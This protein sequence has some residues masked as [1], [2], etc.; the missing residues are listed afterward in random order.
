MRAEGPS[1]DQRAFTFSSSEGSSVTSGGPIICSEGTFMRP[2]GPLVRSKTG[3]RGKGR[4]ARGQ[5]LPPPH[6]HGSRGDKHIFC[7]P[8]ISPG[9]TPGE[10]LCRQQK[11]AFHLFHSSEGRPLHWLRR[12]L[13]SSKSNFPLLPSIAW[14]TPDKIWHIA[15]SIGKM[16]S[17][18]VI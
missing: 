6:Q 14:Y 3:S 8:P 5:L 12:P 16:A 9:R 10:K 15:C 18:R 11:T 13:G 17:R 7:Q 4:G 2:K 1:R